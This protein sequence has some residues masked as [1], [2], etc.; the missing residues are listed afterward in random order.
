MRK[1]KYN[2]NNNTLVEHGELHNFVLSTS[3]GSQ[4]ALAKLPSESLV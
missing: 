3:L 1:M 2:N 4:I